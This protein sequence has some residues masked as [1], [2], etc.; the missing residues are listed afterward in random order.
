MWHK[1]EKRP[2]ET[3]WSL[4]SL[5]FPGILS[6]AEWTFGLSYIIYD[7]NN[8]PG[9]II[10]SGVC[11]QALFWKSKP[12]FSTLTAR[13][14]TCTDAWGGK[15]SVIVRIHWSSCCLTCWEWQRVATDAHR[16]FFLP[17]RSSLSFRITHGHRTHCL[18]A[19]FP[20][21]QFCF[22]QLKAAPGFI[23]TASLWHSKNIT[24]MLQRELVM[25]YFFS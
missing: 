21:L 24:A 22:C 8:N 23:L 1:R 13:P 6:T 2:K 19:F 9:D 16:A 11:L 7:V 15:S 17:Q 5:H 4:E 25:E 3:T 10:T 12:P 20:I 18:L 14:C